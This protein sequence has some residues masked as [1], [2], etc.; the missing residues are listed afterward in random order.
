MKLI[1]TFL[2]C[3]PV[4]RDR[5]LWLLV[6]NYYFNRSDSNKLLKVN[7]LN[8]ILFKVFIRKEL[9]AYNK[10]KRSNIKSVMSHLF[11]RM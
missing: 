8:N 9:T 1:L 11:P 7:I 10:G 5:R 6:E 4:S 2:K 3:I